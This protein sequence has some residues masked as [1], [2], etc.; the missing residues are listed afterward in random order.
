MAITQPD[1]TRIYFV[2]KDGAAQ[3]E[4]R[5]G[6]LAL[7]YDA[8]G[9]YY[10]AY[11]ANYVLGGAFNSRINLNLRENKGYTYGAQQRLPRHELRGPVHGP[12]PACAPM[13]RPRR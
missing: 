1:K 13:P 5:V 10:R 2:N 12:A 4:I 8:T 11:L 3:S 7:P 6:Y 9:D